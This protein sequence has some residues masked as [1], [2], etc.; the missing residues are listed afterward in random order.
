MAADTAMI[1]KI[2]FRGDELLSN[3][4]NFGEIIPFFAISYIRRLREIYI[5]I[6]PVKTA[7]KKADESIITPVFPPTVFS[8][9]RMELFS[10]FATNSELSI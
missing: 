7:E 9:S 4:A 6:I 3:S 10:I 8:R 5:P 1:Q 2:A